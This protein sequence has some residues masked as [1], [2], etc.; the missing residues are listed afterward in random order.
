MLVRVFDFRRAG[1]FGP[2]GGQSEVSQIFAFV[3][4]L[5]NIQLFAPGPAGHGTYNFAVSVRK[6]QVQVVLR[7]P[8]VLGISYADLALATRIDG[9][10]FRAK[11]AAE[12]KASNAA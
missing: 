10:F 9:V 8:Q 5:G 4:A 11:M 6:G 7:T 1:V 12:A 3:A 2:P